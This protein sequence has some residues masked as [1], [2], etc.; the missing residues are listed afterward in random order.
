MRRVWLSMAVL[1]ALG[2]VGAG[3]G[4]KA[5]ETAS[6]KVIESAMEAN[7]QDADVTVNAGNM[8]IKTDKEDISFGEGTKLPDGWPDDVPLY[9]GVTLLTAMKMAEGFTIQ[10]MTK[11]SVEKITEF[12]KGELLK[13]GWTEDS[14]TTQ[15]QLAMMNYS[16]EK[17]ALAVILSVADAETSLAITITGK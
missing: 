12:Y 7:G 5:S 16:K 11:D 10:G 2:M 17:R 8:Q 14:I 13:K 4:K 1:V 3:C 15:P 6:E 9:E